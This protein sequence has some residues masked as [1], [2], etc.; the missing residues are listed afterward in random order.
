[1]NVNVSLSLIKH[2]TANRLGDVEVQIQE[3]LNLTLSTMSG[4]VVRFTL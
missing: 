1:V 4:G 3:F 2:M